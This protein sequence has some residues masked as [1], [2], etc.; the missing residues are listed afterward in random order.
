MDFW[1]ADRLTSVASVI[2]RYAPH[3][4][5]GAKIRDQIEGDPCNSYSNP[6]EAPS[7]YAR[8]VV[9]HEDGKVTFD[10]EMSDGKVVSYDN[11]DVQRVW[12]VHPDFIETFRGAVDTEKKSSKEEIEVPT[13]SDQV[14]RGLERGLESVQEEL[15]T[16]RDVNADFRATIGDTIARLAQDVLNFGKD[17][18]FCKEYLKGYEG[19]AEDRQR[20][21]EQVMK[22]LLEPE[23]VKDEYRGSDRHTHSADES[24][25]NSRSESTASK[26]RHYQGGDRHNHSDNESLKKSKSESTS[27]DRHSHSGDE[28]RGASVQGKNKQSEKFS[29]NDVTALRYGQD[30]KEDRR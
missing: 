11:R 23:G 4:Y 29:W 30:I 6:D 3:M 15:A 21:A 22:G 12:E 20:E 9:H 19:I 13:S 8:N 5:D 7:G 24:V 25:K 27:T 18:P 1:N 14:Y 16:V 10:V 26:N 17:A 2:N 28:Y